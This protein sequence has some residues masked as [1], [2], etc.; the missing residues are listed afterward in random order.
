[1]AVGHA[2]R[3]DGEAMTLSRRVSRASDN[4]NYV[5]CVL[6]ALQAPAVR[7]RFWAKVQRGAPD[8]CWLW[9]GAKGCTFGHGAFTVRLDG[10]QRHVYAHRV[11]WMLA[12]GVIPDQLQVNHHCDVP[13]CVNPAHLYLGTQRDN[14]HDAVRRGRY[15][16]TREP[17]KLSDAS[18]R[19]IR[20]LI[21]D[22]TTARVVARAFGVTPA[23][24]SLIV[25]GQR[26]QHVADLPVT[27]KHSVRRHVAQSELFAT[28]EGSQRC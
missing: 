8:A 21:A 9:T 12:H 24:I 4:A 26:R 23:T 7:R 1:M 11:S 15:P 27:P 22:G 13:R 6:A 17:R 25:S 16:L 28:E 14:V 20:S 3:N 10:A 5:S 2:E 19:A 18:V